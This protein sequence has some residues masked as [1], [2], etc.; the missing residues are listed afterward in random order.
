MRVLSDMFNNSCCEISRSP[1]HYS[2][3]FNEVVLSTCLVLAAIRILGGKMCNKG[4]NMCKIE[5]YV[6]RI[7]S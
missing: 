7:G 1:S 3:M 2:C 4:E 6:Q 5:I